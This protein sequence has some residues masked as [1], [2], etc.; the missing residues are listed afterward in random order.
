MTALVFGQA[1]QDVCKTEHVT[2][3]IFG[4][5][6]LYSH[7]LARLCRQLG[8]AETTQHCNLVRKFATEVCGEASGCLDLSITPNFAL[9]FGAG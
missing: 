7:L 4:P 8:F 5:R 6:S 3:L 1:G 9:R 2:A